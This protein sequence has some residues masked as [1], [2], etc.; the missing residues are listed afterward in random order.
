MKN[1]VN[2]SE[3]YVHKVCCETFLSVWSYA[4]PQGKNS[5]KELCDILVVCDPHIIIISVKEITPTESAET[6]TDW[7]RWRR[8]AIEASAKQ[9][10]GAE[11]WIG[12]ASHVIKCN[13]EKGLPLP[14]LH[15]RCVHRI[16][17]AFGSQGK[18]PISFGDFGKGFVHV[19][20]E[21]SFNILLRNLD[22][23]QDFVGYL[24]KK[25]SL[26]I[27][28]V[29]T[30]IEGGEEDLLAIYLHSGRDFPKSDLLVIGDDLWNGFKNKPE[31][32][33]KQREDE[34]S[35]VWDRII[36]TIGKDI[37]H[38]NMEF[39][40]SL[41]E[42]EVG[43]RT[44]ANENRFSRRLLGRAFEEFLNLAGQ[45]K[46]RSRYL[47]SPSSVIYVFLAVPHGED[48]KFRLTELSGRCF[49]ARS[50]NQ[51]SRV[52]VGIG[53]ERPGTGKGFSFDLVYLYKETWSSEDQKQAEYAKRE[54]GYFSKPV[55]K[56]YG[57]DDYP[58]T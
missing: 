15:E 32:I 1:I 20:D 55:V 17:V 18:V 14:P 54:F 41:E 52:V 10:Y 33:A 51:T 31:V 39:G 45:S 46:V 47:V 25:E 24:S 16:A 49:V 27:S 13:G 34:I 22:T 4:N 21:I 5:S 29:K 56:S 3:E 2:K 28:G 53:T 44:M 43:I 12:A 30:V 26:Y 50:I 58:N 35:Y 19:L 48:R 36:E 9:I 37:L 6:K 23:I 7:A 8:K 40:H 38:G 11:R 57:E 42:S